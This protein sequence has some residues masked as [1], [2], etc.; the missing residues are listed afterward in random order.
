MTTI[1]SAM[2]VICFGAVMGS[3]IANMVFVIQY[4]IECYKDK[5]RK[6]KEKESSAKDA[7]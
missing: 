5:K 1:Q 2:L 6:R 3:F 4:A 7:E